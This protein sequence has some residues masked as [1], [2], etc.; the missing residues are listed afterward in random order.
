MGD[1]HEVK[2]KATMTREQWRQ[3]FLRAETST[4]PHKA[5]LRWLSALAA[6]THE[7]AEV[8]VRVSTGGISAKPFE[9]ERGAERVE[10]ELSRDAVL[11][12]KLSAIQT[13]LGNGTKEGPPANLLLRSNV[14]ASLKDV[15]PAGTLLRLV[16]KEAI[17]PDSADLDEDE[18]DLEPEA[19]K[20]K[21]EAKG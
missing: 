16:E 17:L 6:E 14:L 4:P 2:Y 11:G 20:A 8:T 10:Q 5:A 9:K 3:T 19:E 15:G 12:I 13:M 18:L 7:L 1:K 21:A